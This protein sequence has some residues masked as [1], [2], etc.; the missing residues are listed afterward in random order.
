MVVLPPDAI[1]QKKKLFLEITSSFR[2]Q[3][4]YFGEM[5]Q[6]VKATTD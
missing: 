5:A 3:V 6:E 1:L 4:M 2:Y